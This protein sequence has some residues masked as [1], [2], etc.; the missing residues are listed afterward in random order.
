MGSHG[1]GPFES[2]GAA[3]LL[4]ELGDTVDR[5]TRRF[6]FVIAGELSRVQL[7]AGVAE[8]LRE[9]VNALAVRG[10]AAFSEEPVQVLLDE[11]GRLARDR[12]PGMPSRLAAVRPILDAAHILRHDAPA[13]RWTGA[14]L[15]DSALRRGW[16][17]RHAALLA[18]ASLTLAPSLKSYESHARRASFRSR[19]RS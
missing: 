8:P 12:P 2:D 17:G 11:L 3:D 10:R 19:R 14:V 4:A 5:F 6:F 16:V 7:P 15:R 18:S 1:L 9:V 13:H